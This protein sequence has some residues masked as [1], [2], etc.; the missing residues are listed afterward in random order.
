MSDA[1]S[2]DLRVSEPAWHAFATRLEQRVA[3]AVAAGARVAGLPGGEVAVLLT[4]DIEMQRL[5]A[6]WRGRDYPTDVLSFAA[7]EAQAPHIGDLALGHG[8]CARDADKTG[9]PL[10]D[11]LSHLIVHGV[12]HLAGH[13]HETGEEADAME[14]LE[15]RALASLGLSNP[16]SIVVRED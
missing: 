16:Y 7:S 15:V 3:E 14:T 6:L 10:A 8:V 5:N 2:A 12:L 4:D 9:K 13:D 11:H 1:V